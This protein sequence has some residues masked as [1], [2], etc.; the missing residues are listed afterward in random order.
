MI[1]KKFQRLPIKYQISSVFFL[2]LL[3]VLSGFSILTLQVQKKQIL[4]IT[5]VQMQE[6]AQDVVEKAS[7]LRSTVDSREYE[8]KMVYYLSKQRSEYAGRGYHLSQFVIS[9]SGRVQAFGEMKKVPLNAE[10]Q[11]CIFKQKHGVIS[12][13][14][15]AIAY[16]YNLENQTA[17]LLVLPAADYLRPVVVLQKS[18]LMLG[19]IT[20]SFSLLIILL[21]S[22]YITRPI[23]LLAKAAEEVEAGVLKSKSF[24]MDMAGELALLARSFESMIA[25][26]KKFVSGLKTVVLQLNQASQE[27]SVNS[28]QVKDES[29]AISIQ[30]ENINRQVSEQ[31]DSMERI[32]DSVEH[33]QESTAVI[34]NM[35]QLTINISRQ[36]CDQSCKGRNSME[37][38]NQQIA[39]VHESTEVTKAALQHLSRRVEEIAAFNTSVESIARQIKLVAFNAAIEAAR[40]GKA[41]DSFS[42]VADEVSK[43]S[44]ETYRFSQETGKIIRIMLQDFAELKTDFQCVF[45]KVETSAE[46]TQFSAEI[47]ASIYDKT[48]ENNQAII[49]VNHQSQVIAEE[50][51]QLAAEERKIY[52]NSMLVSSSIPLMLNSAVNQT[53]STDYNMQNSLLLVELADQLK[54]LV[55]TF[56][57]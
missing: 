49:D 10:Q 4:S 29:T 8:D 1:L 41:G 36:I 18:I 13:R 22:L 26:L 33:L 20:I 3:V 27:L 31:M 37:E 12:S 16:E 44:Q 53:Q 56:D 2:I 45:E 7:I 51:N 50:I 25:T 6:S 32:R 17:V 24:S 47:F 54:E 9:P 38:L 42:V 34:N 14:G 52:D 46:L 28:C 35:N 19:I 21:I 5:T 11:T 39:G 48:K 40:A 30:L 43:L 55:R 23:L 57:I 15:Y